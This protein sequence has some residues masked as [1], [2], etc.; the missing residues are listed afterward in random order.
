MIQDRG[1]PPI[2]ELTRY[3]VPL[4][5]Q[6]A[7]QGLTYPLVAMVASRGEG[8]PLNLA[9]LAQSNTVLFLLGTLGFGLVATG[10][11]YGRNR[12][13][14]NRFRTVTYR[15]AFAV[16]LVQGVLCLP[17]I[18]RFLFERLIGLPPSIAYP[19][20]ITLLTS[21]PLQ[22]LFFVRIP[23]QVIMYNARVSARA[24]M[25][26]LLR[27][28]LTA[29]LSPI[30]CYFGVVGPNWAI[31]CLTLPVLLEVVASAAL[32]APYRYR[33]VSD[34][35]QPATKKEMF[36][37][38]LPLSIGGYLLAFSSI[39]LGAVIAR[40]PDPERMLPVYYLALGL[41]T[42]VAY[43][44]FRVQEVVLVFG[45]RKR[46]DPQTF[47]FSLKAGA[48]LGILP[49]IFIFPGL[50]EFYYVRT[51]NLSIEDL[52]LVRVAA[53]CLLLHPVMV[54]VRAQGEGLAASMKK[55]LMVIVGQTFYMAMAL[56]SA[57][58]SLILGLP[59]NVIGA[60][61]LVFGNLASTVVLRF[62]LLWMD[63]KPMNPSG[64]IGVAGQ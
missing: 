63:R 38:N 23:Y 46:K 43:G 64:Y 51:Q 16:I 52:P 11:V 54:A 34:P 29:V 36:L 32:A 14:F 19:A 58:I 25:A 9:G 37:F 33:M 4:A 2:K 31:F 8:G 39:L 50:A 53:F 17:W 62:F 60:V 15:T 40:A 59:G 1:R 56:I 41:T 45:A 42:P 5:L 7:S 48:V 47:F 20:W 12:E 6:S 35:T 61:G 49:L 13:G 24:S 22:F 57:V 10:M 18:S 21:I 27:I 28:V 44:A 30:F 55:P 3:F 26:T